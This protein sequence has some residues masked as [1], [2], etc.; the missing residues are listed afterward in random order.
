MAGQLMVDLY[1]CDGNIIDDLSKIREIARNMIKEIHSEIV[2]E[3]FHKFEPIGITYIA[4]ITTSHFSIHTWPEYEYAAVDIFSCDEELPDQVAE[5]LGK[6]FG[7]KNVVV[8]KFERDIEG[9]S[10]V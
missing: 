5:K 7:A 2:E 6:A 1:G 9:R 4:V 8:H 3:C 10:K